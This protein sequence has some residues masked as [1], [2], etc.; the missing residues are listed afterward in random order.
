MFSYKAKILKLYKPEQKI[1]A[2]VIFDSP[3]SGNIYPQDFKAM[4]PLFRLHQLEDR[5]VDILYGGV[6]D[7]GA[8]LLSAQFP[9]SYID[10]NRAVDDIDMGMID[11]IL[12]FDINPSDKSYMGHGLIWRKYPHKFTMKKMPMYDRLLNVNEITNRIE[13]YWLPYRQILTAEIENIYHQ[14]GG[15]WHINCHSMPS[16]SSPYI[17]GGRSP[18][19]NGN[20]N[21]K[22]ADMV[23]GTLDGHSCSKEFSDLI[24][25]HLK[26]LG[27]DIC[28]NHPYKG[29]DI[30]KSYGDPANNRHSIQIEIN[31]GIYMDEDTLKPNKHF[32]ILQDNL[33]SLCDVICKYARSQSH[34]QSQPTA[35]E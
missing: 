2:P 12:P 22:R 10:P 16:G 31:R 32:K 1:A 28:I 13:K 14:Y 5:M 17:Q 6:V 19:I 26:Q 11:G 24:Y 7:L 29:A 23:F 34:P 21:K 35:A 18:Y 9:R 8:I 20:N 15:V 25:H 4:P 33:N 27:Y 3:H 30:I